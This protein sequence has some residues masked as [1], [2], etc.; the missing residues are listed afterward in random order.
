[1]NALFIIACDPGLTSIPLG[2]EVVQVLYENQD[3]TSYAA[4]GQMDYYLTDDLTLTAGLRWTKEEKDFIAAQG[5]FTTKERQALRN[6]PPAFGNNGYAD[7]SRQ[8]TELSPKVGL[9]YNLSEDSIAFVTYSE[10]F[11]SGGFFGVNQNVRDYFR[12]IYDPEISKTWEIGYKSQH[13]DDRLRFNITYFHSD[14]Q[15]KQESFIAL[16]PDT[17]TVVT[18]MENAAEAVYKGVELETEFVLNEY[19]RGFFNYGSLDAKYE[20]FFVDLNPNDA[21]TTRS[22]GSFLNPRN[23]PEFT[24]GIGGTLTIPVENGVVEAF[25]KFSRIDERDASVLNLQQS[26]IG[27]TDSLTATIGY[28]TDQWS[29][30]A[31]C[32]NCTDEQFE[33]F[34][35]IATLFAAGTI[36]KP[37]S[38]GIEFSYEF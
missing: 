17:S 30:A 24:W 38:Y 20:D 10:G 7:P 32:R 2:T 1:M 28:Y 8:W 12:D 4:Y 9:T 11:H 34:I 5:Y 14:F 15:D 25:A 19:L 27:E 16:D 26:K 37:R 13:F 35:P 6:P 31:Y 18:V 23:A 36:N 33:V 3:T 22:D 21:D 29:V